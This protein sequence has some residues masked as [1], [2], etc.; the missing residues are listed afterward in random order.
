MSMLQSHNI[1]DQASSSGGGEVAYLMADISNVN[2]G[3]LKDLLAS[4]EEVPAAIR[5]RILY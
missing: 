5:T 1:E 3:E 2:H 4:L